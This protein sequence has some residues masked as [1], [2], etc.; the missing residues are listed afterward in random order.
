MSQQRREEVS[1]VSQYERP[2][3]L[4]SYTVAEMVEESAVCVLYGGT[5]TISES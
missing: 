2:E 5:V 1:N 4:A 3:I